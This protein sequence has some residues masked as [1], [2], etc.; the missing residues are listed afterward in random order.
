MPRQPTHEY[1]AQEGTKNIWMIACATPGEHQTWQY[2]RHEL[3]H[4]GKTFLIMI[5]PPAELPYTSPTLAR[6]DVP[7][8]FSNAC[9]RTPVLLRWL[10]LLHAGNILK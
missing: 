3:H 9:W 2:A 8:L 7:P 6:S 5:L 10:H 4:E 1:A